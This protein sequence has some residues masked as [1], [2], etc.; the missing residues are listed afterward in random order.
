MLH[1]SN[2]L[3]AEPDVSNDEFERTLFHGSCD[4]M[5]TTAGIKCDVPSSLRTKTQS[6]GT[7]LFNPLFFLLL[8]YIDDD[9]VFYVMNRDTTQIEKGLFLSLSFFSFEGGWG[10]RE[11]L[12]CTKNQYRMLSY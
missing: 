3:S 6:C 7:F 12:L 10:E 9:F 5:Y 2:A 8:L 1:C 11:Q 4:N